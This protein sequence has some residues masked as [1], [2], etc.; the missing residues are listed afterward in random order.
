LTEADVLGDMAAEIGMGWRRW[1]RPMMV[2]LTVFA[3]LVLAF[4]LSVVLPRVLARE[5]SL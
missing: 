2:G 1:Y 3:L 4:E 5:G